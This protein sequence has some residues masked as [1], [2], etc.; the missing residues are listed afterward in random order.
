MTVTVIDHRALTSAELVKTAQQGDAEAFGQLYDRYVDNIYRF[1]YFRTHNRDLAE[2]LTADTFYKA[3]KRIGS[4]SWTGQDFGGWLYTIARNLIADHFKKADT[5]LSFLIPD[6]PDAIAPHG[7]GVRQPE[8]HPER[9]LIEHLGNVELLRAVMKLKP[10]QQECIVLRFLLEVP[11]AEVAE[12]MGKTTGAVKALQGRAV[13][14]LRKLTVN[15][16]A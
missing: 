15:L 2:D 9:A 3:L 14:N 8:M 10:E 11:V 1:I 7:Q 5:R 4:W 6:I 12:I 16:A 13:N